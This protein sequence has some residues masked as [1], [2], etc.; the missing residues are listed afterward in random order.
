MDRVQMLVRDLPATDER[1]PQGA[2]SWFAFALL[3]RD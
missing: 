3:R 2:R 1:D